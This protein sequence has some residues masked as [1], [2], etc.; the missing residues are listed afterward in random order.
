[1]WRAPSE[2]HGGSSDVAGP[3]RSRWLDIVNLVV[4]IL[5][6]AIFV[7]MIP[8][9]T[10][11][12]DRQLLADRVARLEERVATLEAMARTLAAPTAL[13]LGRLDIAPSQDSASTVGFWIRNTG[14]AAARNVKVVLVLDAV[15][16]PWGEAVDSVHQ[17]AV[18]TF[19]PSLQVAA[20]AARVPSMPQEFGAAAVTGDNALELTLDVLPPGGEWY[21]VVGLSDALPL[22]TCRIVRSGRVQVRPSRFAPLSLSA[23][24]LEVMRYRLG[25]HLREELE[26][27]GWLAELAVSAECLNCGGTTEV[28]RARLS[29]LSGLFIRSTPV[30]LLGDG[31]MSFVATWGVTLSATLSRPP[32]APLP[33]Y[34]LGEGALFQDAFLFSTYSGGI[35]RYEFSPVSAPI[36]VSD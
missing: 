4:S 35:F 7:R 6:L 28:A 31:G 19:P 21:I 29:S 9:F 33:A 12:R 16:P 5:I 10:A 26:R 34:C 13:S 1:M 14:L 15:A 11:E 8:L 3:Q 18:R 27:R 17:L 22:E 20:Q 30:R 23:N 32:G 25:R 24:A 2:S 36:V